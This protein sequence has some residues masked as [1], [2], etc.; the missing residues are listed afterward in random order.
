MR[1]RSQHRRRPPPAGRRDKLGRS[2]QTSHGWDLT[3]TSP[4]CK[5][6]AEGHKDEADNNNMLGGCD[7]VRRERGGRAGHRGNDQQGLTDPQTSE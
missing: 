1:E 4:D 2:A 3:H 7:T 6:E 5:K